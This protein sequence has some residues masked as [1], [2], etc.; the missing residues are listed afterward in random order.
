MLA[1]IRETKKNPFIICFLIAA[2]LFTQFLLL[3]SKTWAA[4]TIPGKVEAESF[5]AM[6]G[7]Q[8][9]TTTDMG[10]GLDVGWIDTGDWMDYSINVPSADTYSV[11]FRVAS[12]NSTGQ[13]QLRDS[14]GNVLATV[15]VPN[16]GGWQAWTTVSTYVNL[17][18]G[19]Q[20]LRLYAS[21][22]GFNVNWLNIATSISTIIANA[23]NSFVS[24]E[25]A[26]AS[27]LVAN[28]SQAGDWEKFKVINNSDGTVSFLSIANNN[29]VTADL[30]QGSK[31]IARATTI[32]GWEKFRMIDHGN[33]K[34]ALQ[35][36][37]NNQYISADLN[38]GAV[39][40][41]NRGTASGWEEFTIST[42]TN[43]PSSSGFIVSEAQF[44][45]IFPNRNPFYT[46]SG[47]VTAL[48]AYPGFTT[49]GSTTV[50][51]QE[52]AAFL[53][54]VSHE[55]GGLYY[56]VEQNTANY[57][58]YC[59]SSSQYPC[60]PGKQYYGRGPLQLSWNYNYGTA[61]TA[62]GLP[63][64]SNPDLVAQDSSVAW[65][66][67]LWFWNTQTGS[68]TMTAHDAMVNSVGFGETIRTINGALECNG[69]NPGQVQSR[70]NLYKTIT[71]IL[72]VITGSNLGC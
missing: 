39:L 54:N 45:Q 51:K 10:G 35:A 42:S 18:A 52:A 33:G 1:N 56:I 41:A 70:I 49:T 32:Q 17:G 65:K 6:S 59:A 7:I 2:L 43:P 28:R 66:T 38:Q 20:T 60:A 62:L 25:N 68:G 71:S 15:N 55:T 58:Y 21:S 24:S 5:I 26:G 27:P 3:P 37:A 16:T 63:L 50:Q 19:T 46:Y 57:P 22:G 36:L 4:S 31:L 34:V 64:L 48:S 29:Y 61:G 53:A 9:E 67:A 11:E 23:N 72:G 40:Y 30:N 13:V 44:N 69:G 14:V 47:L 8:T 12:I